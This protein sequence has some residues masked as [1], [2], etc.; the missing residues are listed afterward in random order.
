MNCNIKNMR[1]DNVRDFLILMNMLLIDYLINLL[2]DK[3]IRKARLKYKW[4]FIRKR[5]NVHTD[6]FPATI[7]YAG[8]KFT[9][10]IFYIFYNNPVYFNWKSI[11]LGLF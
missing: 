3:A 5:T 2:W 1:I 6:R 11:K 7:K 4:I 9:N 10:F 8:V